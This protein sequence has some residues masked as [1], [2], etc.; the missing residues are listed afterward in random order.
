MPFYGAA[1][2]TASKRSTNWLNELSITDQYLKL[3]GSGNVRRD[4]R[5]VEH[6]ITKVVVMFLL[7]QNET[8]NRLWQLL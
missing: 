5:Q 4:E 6:Y 7:F 1:S 8:E 3:R 2:I